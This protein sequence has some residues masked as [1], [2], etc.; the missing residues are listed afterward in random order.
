V[1]Q[2]GEFG[3]SVPGDVEKRDLAHKV[4]PALENPHAALPPHPERPMSNRQFVDAHGTL[5]TVWD[6]Y[7]SR[8]ERELE[9]ARLR[10]AED[11]QAAPKASRASL[12]LDG[13]FAEG[14]LCFESPDAK[15]RLAPIP[16]GWERLSVE[17]LALLCDRASMVRRHV[18]QRGDETS[19]PTVAS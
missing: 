3:L 15:R 9:L 2:K 6:V 10:A 4:Q 14:W 12:P 19:P 1:I 5:W 17:G 13:H 8:V 7:P 18:L 11:A 16:V